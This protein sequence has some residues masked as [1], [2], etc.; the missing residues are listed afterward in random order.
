M[1]QVLAIISLP[2]LIVT[3]F[4]FFMLVLEDLIASFSEL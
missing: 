2:M 3:V 4:T 1:I